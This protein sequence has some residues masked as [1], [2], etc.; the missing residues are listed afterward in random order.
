MYWFSEII[1]TRASYV[2][3]NDYSHN[4]IA[5]DLGKT[6]P[7]SSWCFYYAWQIKMYFCSKLWCDVIVFDGIVCMLGVFQSQI[8]MYQIH[9]NYL[10]EKNKFC[11]F[12]RFERE[13][14][15]LTPSDVTLSQQQTA[16]LETNIQFQKTLI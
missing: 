13:T 8:S 5:A 10:L 16:S 3:K 1:Y 2:Y 4:C 11:Q 7:V 14:L 9:F 15:T 12:A 6:T